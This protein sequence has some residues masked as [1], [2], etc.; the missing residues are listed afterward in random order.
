M[1]IFVDR[2]DQFGR[3]EYGIP[4]TTVEEAMAFARL[5]VSWSG[6]D[7]LDWE[8]DYAVVIV[9][10]DTVRDYNPLLDGAGKLLRRGP[11]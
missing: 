10:G 11:A 2:S 8:W 1:G 4:F 9:N 7:S 3:T 5:S 6:D